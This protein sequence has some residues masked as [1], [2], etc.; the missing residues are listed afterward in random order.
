MGRGKHAP[1]GVFWYAG[2]R[3]AAHR[4]AA[5]FIHRLDID[6]YHIDH[7]CPHIP[8]PNTLC[9]EHVQPL[10]LLEN[11]ALQHE[12]RRNFIHLEVGLIQ[13]RDLYG[14]EP[15]EVPQ[16]DLVPFYVEPAWLRFGDK[17]GHDDYPF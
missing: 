5:R 16:E 6:N 14:P 8:I 13:Y 7:C 3:W 9:V 1:Y 11:V 12:R 2:R 4:W 15:E 17:D 10:T